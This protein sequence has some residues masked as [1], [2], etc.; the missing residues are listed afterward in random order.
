MIVKRLLLVPVTMG[1]VVSVVFGL[2]HAVPGDPVAALVGERASPTDYAAV[3]HTL[4]L[5]RPLGVQYV[6]YVRGVLTGDWGVS[7]VTGKPVLGMI[8][9]RLGATAQLGL[10]AMLVAVLVGLPVGILTGL[11]RGG[12]LAALADAVVLGVVAVPS[13]V[14]G[15]LLM[16]VFAVGAGWFPVS[17]YESWRGLV[18]PA[19]TLGL[20]MGAVLARL[21]ANSLREEMAAD[22]VRQVVAK[23]AGRVRVVGRHA[24]RNSW[25]P[26]LVIFCLQ[27]GMVLTGTVLTEAVFGWPGVGTLL[28]EA[29]Q[30]RDYPVVQGC[31][32]LISLVYGVLGVAGDV[33][34]AL[35]DP[36]VE[37]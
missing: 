20:G 17:G 16:L 1:V 18:L 2:L 12:A 37:S 3:A 23:G 24:L 36:R 25:G 8:G 29:L 19:V 30:G 15:V 28:V 35:L 31:I 11:M 27:M 13:F 21:L 26:V 4:G 34:A 14:V 5:D 32:L 22:Y 33:G 9:E 6:S 10:S 7:L